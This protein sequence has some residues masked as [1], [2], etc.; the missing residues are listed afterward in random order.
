[1][2][3]FPSLSRTSTSGTT[4]VADR[5]LFGKSSSNFFGLSI[6]TISP[7]L[8]RPISSTPPFVLANAQMVVRQ[9]SRQDSFHSVVWFSKVISLSLHAKPSPGGRNK[10]LGMAYACRS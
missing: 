6:P 1:M 5:I 3:C 7:L 9:S 8:R 4:P 2:Y 10:P